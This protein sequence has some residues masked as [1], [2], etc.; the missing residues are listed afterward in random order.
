MN[1]I[2]GNDAEIDS[3]DVDARIA[4]LE[5]GL[6]RPDYEP[7]IPLS[8]QQREELLDLCWIRARVI[9]A[10][11]EGRWRAGVTLVRDDGFHLITFNDRTYYYRS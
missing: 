8:R 3:R 10:L 9:R 5:D 11:G 7:G 4:E 1:E 2:T 6:P